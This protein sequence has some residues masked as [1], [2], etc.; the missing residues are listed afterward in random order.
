MGVG[1]ERK[2]MTLHGGENQMLC[3][4]SSS[5]QQS[6]KFIPAWAGNTVIRCPVICN[7]SVHPRVGGEHSFRRRP[8]SRRSRRKPPRR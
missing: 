1:K 6:A 3:S 5:N 2:I 7:L 8:R 4:V